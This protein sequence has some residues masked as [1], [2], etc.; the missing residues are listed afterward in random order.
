M[1]ARSVPLDLCTDANEFQADLLVRRGDDMRCAM[2]FC[3]FV[4]LGSHNTSAQVLPASSGGCAISSS[5]LLDCDWT[6]A[7]TLRWKTDMKKTADTSAN[8]RSKL[9]ITRCMLAPGAP[10]SPLVKGHDVLIVGMNGGEFVNENRSPPSHVDVLPGLVMLMP[11]KKPYLLKNVG[12]QNL[13]LLL[14]EVRK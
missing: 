11:G 1:T 7:I 6:S 10:L 14:I 8:E 9:F 3:L 2:T 13:D 12:E 5:G 4:L